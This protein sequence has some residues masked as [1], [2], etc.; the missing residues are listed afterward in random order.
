MCI[1]QQVGEWLLVIANVKLV[2]KGPNL[3]LERCYIN[4]VVLTYFW[5]WCCT[6]NFHALALFASSLHATFNLDNMGNILFFFFEQLAVT[7]GLPTG[8]RAYVTK[9][10]M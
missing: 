10:L 4:T 8:L 5:I 9:G 1:L 2:T 6:R 7:E 3:C